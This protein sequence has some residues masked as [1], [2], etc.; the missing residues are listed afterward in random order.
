MNIL[1]LSAYCTPEI[2]ASSHLMNDLYDAFSK[3][4]IRCICYVPEPTRGVSDEVRKKYKKK[5]NESLYDGYLI[6]RRFFMFREKKNPIQRAIRYFLCSCIQY[7]KAIN[8]ENID[9]IFSGSTPPTN[10]LINVMVAK[11]LEK[12]YGYKVPFVYELQDIFPDSL[13]NSNM[14][15][16]GSVLWKIG[17]KIEDYTYRNAD[18]IIVPSETMKR[19]ILK[20]GVSNNKVEVISNWIDM[21]NV[22]PVKQ[23]ENMVLKEL[24]LGEKDFIV[25]Y[26]GNFGAAQGADIILKVANKLKEYTDMK[27]VIFGGGAYFEEAKE[28][29]KV[30]KNVLIRDLLPLEYV[31]EVYSLGDLALITCKS[32]T[33]A[34]GM[35]SKTWSI[36]ACN[37]PI[38]A[39]FDIDSELADVL[40]FANSGECVEPENVEKLS[41]AILK[42]YNNR[43]SLECNSR[44]YV[45][46]NASKESCVKKYVKVIKELKVKG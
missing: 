5:K 4:N 30:M 41:E 23:E 17:R 16:K 9:V 18:K 2:T 27:F 42:K 12:K 14:T 46:L 28:E 44:E 34:A 38:I 39:S 7:H 20:K 10:G 40:K 22:F 6:V 36:M 11:K 25:L 31:S 15:K 1:R 43:D 33:G 26:A 8:T 13:V 35:P 45:Q 37:T 32:G 3:N 29:A 19:N 24:E 21:K